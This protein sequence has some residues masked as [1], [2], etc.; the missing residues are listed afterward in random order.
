MA[1][2][3][4]CACALLMLSNSPKHTKAYQTSS[5]VFVIAMR[6][7]NCLSTGGNLMQTGIFVQQYTHPLVLQCFLGNSADHKDVAGQRYLAF[8]SLVVVQISR[9]C[10][11]QMLWWRALMHTCQALLL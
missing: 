10:V 1:A 3:C 6:L 2:V 8:H 7:K 5:G 9:G 4:V 11:C